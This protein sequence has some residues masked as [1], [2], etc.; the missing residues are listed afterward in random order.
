MLHRKTLQRCST[1]TTLE[2]KF[3]SAHPYIALG[4]FN[5]SVV[6]MQFIREVYWDYEYEEVVTPNIYNFD[7]WKTSGHADHY[8][9]NMFSFDIEKQEFGLKPMNCP[10]RLHLSTYNLL[11]FGSHLHSKTSGLPA[12]MYKLLRLIPYPMWSLASY[13][14]N[15]FQL[16]CKQ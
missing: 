9:Q 8:K 3:C 12:L 1:Q 7:L 5:I 11:M 2:N 13:H 14:I 4:S 6:G 10:G 16:L 15:T